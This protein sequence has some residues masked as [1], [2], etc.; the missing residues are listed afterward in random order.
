MSTSPFTH[1]DYNSNDGMLTSVWGPTL[2]HSLHTI[3]FNYPVFPS[4]EQKQQYFNYFK[5]LQDIL[6]CKYCRD[7]F[8]KNLE[9]LP[10][11]SEVMANR[12]N[13]SRWLYEMHNLVNKNLEKPIILSYEQVRDRYE[14]FRSR[15]LTEK[16]DDKKE[17]GCTVPKYGKKPGSV[18][19]IIPRDEIKGESII[20]DER[21]IVKN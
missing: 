1:D 13:L 9:I 2:W 19:H 11:N 21:T 17:K 15:C 16:I 3:S 8:K 14:N 5:S 6:P 12:N 18:I 10:L 4:R 20:I 7:N